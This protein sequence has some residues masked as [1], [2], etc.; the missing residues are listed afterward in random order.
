[1]ALTLSQ[2]VQTLEA[3]HQLREII[4]GDRW[5][6]DPSHFASANDPYNSITY[7]ARNIVAGSLLFCKGRFR[8]EYL[9][10]C[11]ARGL[12][13]Y[14]SESDFSDA[15]AACGIIVNDVRK[16]MSLLSSQFYGDPQKELTLIG[17]TGTKGKTT[18]AYF[19]QAVLNA[20]SGGRAALFS[21]VSNC[22]D[23]RTY[24]DSELTTPESMDAFRMMRSAVDNGMRY[25]VMEVSSQAYKVDRVYGL[26]FDIGAFLNISPDHISPIEHPTF[27]DYFHCK[28]Q[29]TANSR[30]LVLGAD[31]AHADLIE[32]D[33]K[34]A[35]IPVTT[36]ALHDTLKDQ[37]TPA[38]TIAWPADADHTAF[39]IAMPRKDRQGSLS[40]PGNQSTE[41]CAS[42]D[43]RTSMPEANTGDPASADTYAL[44]MDGDFNY[45]NAAAA[46][47]IASLAGVDI[48]HNPKAAHRLDQ[49]RIA[50]R[51]E[52]FE[53]THGSNVALI[54]FAHNYA[55]V[56]AVIDYAL[57]RYGKQHPRLT[58]VTGTAGGKANDRRRE[59]V[60]A[61]QHRVDT[62]ILTT[63]DPDHDDPAEICR[64]MA[65]HVTDPKLDIR[66]ILDRA[67]A[68]ETAV[69]EARRHDGFDVVLIIGKGEET[70]LKINGRHDPYEGDTH[71]V[72]RLFS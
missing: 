10:D 38:D 1:M 65:S 69:S 39:H 32:Q 6:R 46:L 24:T 51:M 67:Q 14:V 64:D 4:Q 30:A 26:T 47:T 19:T 52:R 28:R 18:T 43:A 7:D 12:K 8:A 36:F 55:S 33:A 48:R 54:D 35:G 66:T 25:L 68:V 9:K 34:A 72:Q 60:E 5:S 17:I 31:C 71:I 58:L 45:A 15:T 59:I 22:L 70:W 53:D 13:A 44:A 20:A 11:D 50:G 56:S 41:S 62:L 61:A 16:S 57:E 2:A 49:V 37:G 21:S 40:E 63:D 29:L 3:H 27:E 42:K 23:G